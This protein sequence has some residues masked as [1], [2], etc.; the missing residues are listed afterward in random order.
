MN[1]K[2]T[3]FNDILP[4]IEESF[5]R[6]ESVVFSPSGQSMLPMFRAG[7]DKVELCPF[8]GKVKK[9][10]VVFFRRADGNFVLHRV[11]EAGESYIIIGDNRIYHDKVA[12]EQIIGVVASFERNGKKYTQRKIRSKPYIAFISARRLLRRVS[13]KIKRILN[14]GI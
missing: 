8:K 9:Y 11:I 13:A 1:N 4:L 12:P 6:G 10:D 7:R 2:K 5:S 14:G 3:Q